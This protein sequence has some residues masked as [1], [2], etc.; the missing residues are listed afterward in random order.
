[1]V[2][3]ASRFAFSRLDKPSK[4]FHDAIVDARYEPAQYPEPMPADHIG[5]LHHWFDLRAISGNRPGFEEATTVAP[6][7]LSI[8]IAEGLLQAVCL[9]EPGIAGNDHFEIRFLLVGEVLW[10][11]QDQVPTTLDGLIRPPFLVSGS[12]RGLE[13]EGGYCI[14]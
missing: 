10:I 11:L 12:C 9:C 3:I 14:V 2:A 1:M 8:E 6:V 7:L 13:R 5:S 4:G